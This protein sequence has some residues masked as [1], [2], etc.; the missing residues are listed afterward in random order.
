MKTPDSTYYRPSDLG[1][2]GEIGRANP[3]LAEAFFD[4]Y[5]KTMSEGALTKREKSLIALAVA[6]AQKCPYCIDSVSNSCLD[7]GLSEA[8]MIE[9]V[10]VAAALTAGVALVHSTQMLGHV[11]AR[12]ANKD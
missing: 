5:G 6:H 9:A 2:F 12:A 7:Q 8:E 11:D 10:H 1:R 3:V 4:Y